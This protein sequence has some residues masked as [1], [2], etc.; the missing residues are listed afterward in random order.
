[1]YEKNLSPNKSE[2]FLQKDWFTLKNWNY[3]L[4]LGDLFFNMF[5]LAKQKNL[6]EILAYNLSK[7]WKIIFRAITKN[8]IKNLNKSILN[9]IKLVDNISDNKLKFNY[10]TFELV[11]G[12][13][14]KW[15]QIW[16][17]L[18]KLNLDFKGTFKKEYLDITPYSSARSY[19]FYED[20]FEK[21]FKNYKLT[22]ISSKKFI[23]VT[24]KIYI[25]EK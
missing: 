16:E 11:N 14:F 18:E 20:D 7:N 4:I 12:L 24:E 1:M 10:I 8:K 6:L 13:W 3:D 19:V 9:L 22:E 2:I 25:L 17:L 21:I 5:S 23:F 15:K